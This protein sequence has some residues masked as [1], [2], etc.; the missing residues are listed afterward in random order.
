MG[1]G[2]PLEMANE[3]YREHRKLPYRNHPC[4]K[5][6]KRRSRCQSNFGSYG[7]CLCATYEHDWR[8][9]NVKQPDALWVWAD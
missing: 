5:Y 6:L 3:W 2:Y 9:K 4:A 7:E 1:M 8:L